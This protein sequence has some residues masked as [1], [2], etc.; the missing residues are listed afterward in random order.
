MQDLEKHHWCGTG[1]VGLGTIR[2]KYWSHQYWGG[3]SW[4]GVKHVETN[5]YLRSH[6]SLVT[7]AN[8]A[9]R[10]LYWIL[11][12]EKFDLIKETT[13]RTTEPN[14]TTFN[15]LTSVETRT[16]GTWVWWLGCWVVHFFSRCSLCPNTILEERGIPSYISKVFL[17]FFLFLSFF[18]IRTS[19]IFSS[20]D[21]A[22]KTRTSLP[23]NTPWLFCTIHPPTPPTRQCGRAGRR[24]QLFLTPLALPRD[25]LLTAGGASQKATK[26]HFPTQHS[27][28]PDQNCI[29]IGHM[30]YFQGP[31]I[32]DIA[33]YWK[34]RQ[35][36]SK[37]IILLML[38][39]FYV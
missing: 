12:L 13:K 8:P 5:S 33:N 7:L 10:F 21:R 11:Y 19:S 24:K 27:T 1:W 37:H 29:L 22:K 26:Q 3:C 18:S 35:I 15:T 17:C 23:Q 39:A 25:E 4:W 20:P 34:K 38:N 28:H 36:S 30:S 14:P 32:L 31:E 2:V 16:S 6:H 9:D